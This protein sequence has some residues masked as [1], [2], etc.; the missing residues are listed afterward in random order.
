[1]G[2]GTDRQ[3]HTTACAI[4]DAG[5]RE[6]A[7]AT[8]D[9]LSE[10]AMPSDPVVP[11]DGASDLAS[12]ADVK[13]KKKREKVRSAWISFAGRIVAQLV[14][15]V[16]TI[17]LGLMVVQHYG[18]G[19]QRPAEPSQPG[20]ADGAAANAGSPRA[21]DGRL[22]VLVLPFENFSTNSALDPVVD[23]LTESVVAELTR[24]GGLRVLSRTS[25]MHYKGTRKSLRE[26]ARELDVM[27]VVEG[28]IA[29]YKSRVRVVAQLIDAATDDHLWA[30][31]YEQGM[32]DVLELQGSMART[33]AREVSRA[34]LPALLSRRR[35]GGQAPPAG[36]GPPPG[37]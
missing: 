29:Q 37:R 4:G 5:D 22:S 17:A 1:M 26:I 33:I 21:G 7:V 3:V 20:G 8:N 16:A 9:V 13:A 6:H 19:G 36:D 10:S 2:D 15:A 32:G 23:G 27:L 34:A 12:A 31:S 14:G 30:G 11:G 25:S 18:V 28:S 24:G 35:S